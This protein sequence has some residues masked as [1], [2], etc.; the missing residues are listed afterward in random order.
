MPGSEAG[1]QGG[2]EPHGA[3][4]RLTAVSMGRAQGGFGWE[5]WV[6]DSLLGPCYASAGAF[7]RCAESKTR[8]ASKRYMGDATREIPAREK[9]QR[10]GLTVQTGKSEPLKQTG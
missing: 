7:L 4:A 5:G 2:R 6:W 1:P 8:V 3:T 9:G 10:E